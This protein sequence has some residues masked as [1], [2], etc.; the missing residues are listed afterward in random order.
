MKI[1]DLQFARV[2]LSDKVGLNQSDIARLLDMNIEI[3]SSGEPDT[4]ILRNNQLQYYNPSSITRFLYKILYSALH[5]F[6]DN[7]GKDKLAIGLFYMVR[8]YVYS[9]FDP[10]DIQYSVVVSFDKLTPAFIVHEIIEPLIGSVHQQDVMFTKSK[11]ID[12][13]QVVTSSSGLSKS[14]SEI[15]FPVLV[16]NSNV[17]NTAAQHADLLYCYLKSSIGESRTNKV[18]KNILLNNDDNHILNNLFSMLKILHGDPTY[19]IDFL[20]FLQAAVVLSS[21]ERETLYRKQQ[22]ILRAD[23]YMK[24]SI[25]VADES[26]QVF[27]QWSQWSLLMG[28]IEKQLSPM[29]GSAWPASELIGPHEQD[30]Q[31]ILD[32]KSKKKNKPQLNFEEMLETSRDLYNHN[33]IEP[34]QLIE[35]IMKDQRAW[36][37]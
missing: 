15:D 32:E 10:K 21:Q 12:T 6:A 22:D 37:D 4:V 9:D 3:H 30:F 20:K 16:V 17:Y 33:A 2:F 19:V 5:H 11:T 24:K 36:K 27:R 8:N 7:I 28:L 23:N 13:C 29:R 18:I 14:S 26:S 34:G 31:E 1:N 35:V 25:K